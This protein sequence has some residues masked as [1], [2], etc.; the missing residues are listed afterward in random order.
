M[1]GDAT[2]WDPNDWEKHIQKAL[3]LRYAQP[4]GTYQHIAAESGGDYGIEGFAA[5]GTAYQ[6]YSCQNW[7]DSAFL[8]KKQKGK[9]TADIGKFIKNEAELLKILGKIRIGIWNF[10]IPFWNNKDLLV[11]ARKKEE[12]VRKRNPQHVTNDFRISVIT[13]EDFAIECRALANVDLY[14]FDVKEIPDSGTGVAKWLDDNQGL[15]MAENLTRKST[16][17]AQ[18]RSETMRQKF[19][20]Q[21]VKDYIAGQVVL[22]KLELELPEVYENV[23]RR[24]TFRE[25]ELEAECVTNTSVPGAFFDATLSGYKSQ[26]RGVSGI[27]PHA[28]D[29]LAR[30]AVSDWLLRCPLEFE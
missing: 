6:C 18:G 13:G 22:G 24:K 14:Q 20:N 11:H 4:V 2:P 26:L 10:V 1:P 7:T 21:M 16:V 27:S 5:D 17:I 9:I 29:V 3:K 25:S 12:E 8:L 23:I 19:L 15:S 28:A 30:E